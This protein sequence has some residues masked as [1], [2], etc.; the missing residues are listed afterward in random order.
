MSQFFTDFIEQ[1]TFL[2]DE[3]KK[4]LDRLPE[5]ALDWSPADDMNSMAVLIA[6]LAGAERYWTCDVALGKESDRVRS[7]EFETKNRSK[8]D[9]IALLD[10]T[11][12]EISEVVAQI[13]IEDLETIR[14]SSNFREEVSVS[15]CLLHAMEHTA[16]HVGHIQMM[17]HYWEHVHK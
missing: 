16:T 13:K 11:L 14:Y 15:M 10:N 3:I 6:H 17:R 8:A 12:A 2:H 9:L 1:L 4:E 5:E 7:Q